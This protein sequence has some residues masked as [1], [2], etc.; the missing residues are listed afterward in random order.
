MSKQHRTRTIAP[1]KPAGMIPR[2][3]R[4]KLTKAS[5]V[6]LGL[7]HHENVDTVAKGLGNEEIL[8]QMVGGVLTWS[9]VAEVLQAGVPEM[10]AQSQLITRLIDRYKATG[11]VVFTDLDYQEAKDGAG[12]MD[13]LAERVDAYTALQAAI[14]SEDRTNEMASAC[15]A[16][17][18]GV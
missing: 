16:Q 4:P 10:E 11:K 14:W 12:F 5:L 9:Y 8:W 6:D 1:P 15:A 7:A 13:Q 2:W 18:E 17:R 3:C